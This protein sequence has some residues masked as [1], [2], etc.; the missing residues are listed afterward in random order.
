MF[1]L[2]WLPCTFHWH[3]G[4]DFPEIYDMPLTGSEESHVHSEVNIE[5]CEFQFGCFR[6]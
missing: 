6:K 5:T 2:K 3:P 1:G 4:A